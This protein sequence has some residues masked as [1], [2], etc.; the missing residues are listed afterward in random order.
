YRGVDQLPA[1]EDYSM[2]GRTYRYFE[3][4]PLYPFG[5]GMSYSQFIYG[6]LKLSSGTVAAGTRLGVDAEVRNMGPREGDEV[7]EVYLTFPKIA[8]A[9][10]RALRGFTRVHLAAGASQAIHFDLNVRELSM[11]NEAG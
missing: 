10:L 6:N 3:G 7:A 8:G 1:F 2:K 11:V 5:Y 9:P 4:P